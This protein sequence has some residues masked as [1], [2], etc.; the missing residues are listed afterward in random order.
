MATE[1]E[2]S[3]KLDTMR[4]LPPR[5]E[6]LANSIG[7][8]IWPGQ[9]ARLDLPSGMELT[10]QDRREIQ[11]RLDQINEIVTGS[12]LTTNESAKAR[13]SLLTR[14][15]LAKPV[16]GSSSDAAAD[17]RRDM[18]DDAL[19]DIPPWAINNA[20]RRWNRGEIPDLKM[21]NL[22]FAF[23]ADPAVLR[24]LCKIELSPFEAQASRLRQLLATIPIDRA[25]DPTPMPAPEIGSNDGRIVQIGVRRM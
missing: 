12:T 17:A 13:L 9:H 18:Y 1:L 6:K 7:T 23:A 8:T 19:S 3:A 21:G 4:S 15:L 25:M 22:N 5:L 16:S 2:I 10:M 24:R 20:I 11:I 14:M